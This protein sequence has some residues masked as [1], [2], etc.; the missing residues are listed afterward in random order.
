MTSSTERL[1]IT[2]V[3]LAAGTS[4][5]FGSPKQLLRFDGR[6][7]LERVVRNA[8]D[9]A[10]DRVVVVLGSSA[11]EIR[12]HV[13]LGR[14]EIA[15]NRAYGTG[16]AS[17]LLAGLGAAGDSAAL[18]LLLGDQPGVRATVIDLVLQ[19]WRR[20]RPWAAVTDYRGRLGHPFVFASAAF[21]DLR[22]LRGDKAIWQLIERHSERVR[23]IE[24]DRQLPP[25]IDTTDD[26][27]H[28]L[29]DWRKSD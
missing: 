11:D 6:P 13:E 5:R 20:D 4:S 17:S 27:E 18:M 23:K 25:D 7:L 24:I 21:G 10:L 8:T 26:F 22:G 14:A 1:E 15:D 19:A 9:S 16:C 28:A 2:G 29:A 12:T 3:V